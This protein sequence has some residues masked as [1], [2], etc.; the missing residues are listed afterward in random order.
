MDKPDPR[1]VFAAAAHMLSYAACPECGCA[2][3]EGGWNAPCAWCADRALALNLYRQ[4]KMRYRQA[5][6]E[7]AQDELLS[8]RC[9]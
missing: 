6:D 7:Q 5:Q 3:D 4:W 9:A 2:H 8:R 1:Q